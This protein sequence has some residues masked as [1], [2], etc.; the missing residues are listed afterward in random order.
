VAVVFGGSDA[1]NSGERSFLVICA[2][3]QCMPALHNLCSCMSALHVVAR[4]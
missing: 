1:Q 2:T 3:E 4:A